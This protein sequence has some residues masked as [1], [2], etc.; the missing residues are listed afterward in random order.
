M[1]VRTRS[2]RLSNSAPAR[3][4]TQNNSNTGQSFTVSS[5][6][7]PASLAFN[8]ASEQMSDE[9]NL[10]RS[11]E[12]KAKLQL[13]LRIADRLSD[14][15]IRHS[16]KSDLWS[17]L[18]QVH[19]C[20]HTSKKVTF[21][22]SQILLSQHTSQPHIS[23]THTYDGGEGMC[24]IMSVS[25]SSK[26]ALLNNWNSLSRSYT[27][28]AFHTPDWF[29]LLDKW[30]EA[31]NSLI[32]SSSL[33]GESMV[34][35]AIF[36]DAFKA[37]LNPTSLL[38]VF[39]Q[40]GR[41]IAKRKT[42][43]GKV[44]QTLRTSSDSFLSYNFGIRPAIGEIADILAAHGKVQSRLSFLRANVGGY[45]PIRVRGEF[46]SDFVNTTVTSPRILCDEKKSIGVI[47]ALG[48]VRPDL[49][50]ADDWKAYVQYF[51]LH[52]FIGLA[53]ELVPF[54]FVLD[55]VTN[56]GDY[57]SRYTTPHFASP[58]YNIRNIC[59]SYK[60]VLR[61]S[62]WI[63]DQH[64]FSSFSSRL[65][66]GPV[67]MGSMTTTSYQRYPSLPKTSGSVDFSLLGSFHGFAS[68]ALLIQKL[69]K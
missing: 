57:I 38:K 12:A 40:A 63:P 45:V 44:A 55:W 18:M 11:K 43:L 32:P 49:D 48:K 17:E 24:N 26:T 33:L 42:T 19:K 27:A 22:E 65:V 66:G 8:T 61:E 23:F 67:K 34:E 60:E 35:H 31:C 62:Y 52:K 1:R 10:K 6:S 20:T 47:S 51:G 13:R 4:I 29:A 56:A 3:N 36:I 30:H 46:P 25:S 69:L 37:V 21:P 53:W 15:I 2:S 39:L 7:T 68:G 59:H 16:V 9:L 28:D 50:Y 5:G 14:P 58:F 41:K 54:S 64:L